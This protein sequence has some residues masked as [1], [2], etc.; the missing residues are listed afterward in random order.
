MARL[1]DLDRQRIFPHKIR[2][3]PSEQALIVYDLMLSIWQR[4]RPTLQ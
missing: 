2:P 4:V 1:H 3:Y